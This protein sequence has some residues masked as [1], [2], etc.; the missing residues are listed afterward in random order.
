MKG[1]KLN[2]KASKAPKE[3]GTNAEP[4]HESRIGSEKMINALLE[5]RDVGGLERCAKSQDLSAETRE[6]AGLAAVRFIAEGVDSPRLYHFFRKRIK[7]LDY[8]ESDEDVASEYL[9]KMYRSFRLPK[10]VRE[11]ALD[12]ATDLCVIPYLGA[13]SKKLFSSALRRESLSYGLR[14][15]VGKLLVDYHSQLAEYPNHIKILS[16]L[17]KD[18]EIPEEV[19]EYAKTS[20]IGGVEK[21]LKSNPNKFFNVERLLQDFDL[22][23][24]QSLYDLL[25]IA[26]DD[27]IMGISKEKG[28]IK[29]LLELSVCEQF[30]S[31]LREQFAWDALEIMK[32]QRFVKSRAQNAFMLANGLRYPHAVR[33]AASSYLEQLRDQGHDRGLRRAYVEVKFKIEQEIRQLTLSGAYPELIALA[34]DSF[35]GG[36]FRV[37]AEGNIQKAAIKKIEISSTQEGYLEILS[38]ES[39][40]PSVRE[41]LANRT[42]ELFEETGDYAG[43]SMINGLET[44][45]D[46]VRTLAKDRAI[47]LLQDLL[48][49][50]Q[51]EELLETSRR[52]DIPREISITCGLRATAL[53]SQ[54]LDFAGVAS[55]IADEKV[56]EFARRVAS[57][58]LRTTYTAV[59]MATLEKVTKRKNRN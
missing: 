34:K 16:G 7:H 43:L 44:L 55:I 59:A 28:R 38:D 56:P 35:V 21:F 9:Q 50:D 19:R 36:E 20:L 13:T 53:L 46:D 8:F 10:S 1:R 23:H 18:P 29:R 51:V 4:L 52:E 49:S 45:D 47:S 22:E 32:V 33:E 39:L 41:H 40:P 54:E 5:S 17:A 15:K 2:C 31:D 37:L 6:R 42:I 30:P 3:K 25:V 48:Y 14:L 11:A 26:A 27:F 57:E 24:E 58:S 12:K